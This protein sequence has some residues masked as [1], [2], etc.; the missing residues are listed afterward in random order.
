LRNGTSSHRSV[1]VYSR[2]FCTCSYGVINFLQR[3]VFVCN[4]DLSTSICRANCLQGHKNGK[5]GEL[6]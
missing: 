1:R 5:K 2:I 4:D 6:F 3:V